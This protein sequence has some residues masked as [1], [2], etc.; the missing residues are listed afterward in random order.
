MTAAF[1]LLGIIWS[2]GFC[3]HRGLQMQ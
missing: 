1:V 2:M 3:F